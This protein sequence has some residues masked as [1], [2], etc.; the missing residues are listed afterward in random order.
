MHF[1]VS[2]ILGTA[3]FSKIHINLLCW[4]AFCHVGGNINAH[5]SVRVFHLRSL[6]HGWHFFKDGSAV[7]WWTSP[8][9]RH[10][11]GSIL[12][13][14]SQA[15]PPYSDV[16]WGMSEHLPHSSQP[17]QAVAISRHP[18]GFQMISWAHAVAKK[19]AEDRLPKGTI[20]DTSWTQKNMGIPQVPIEPMNIYP[21]VNQHR[22]GTST[23]CR[24]Y[25]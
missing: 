17:W 3:H 7:V 1:W 14:G 8:A 23:I 15:G 20:V 6:C 24:S 4:M 9:R 19:Y 2:P 22:C 5:P 21:R 13:E 25:S 12:M 16:F 10:C 11:H 18:A